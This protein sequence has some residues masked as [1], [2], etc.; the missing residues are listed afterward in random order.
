MNVAVV[1]FLRRCLDARIARLA[2]PPRFHESASGLRAGGPVAHVPG[3]EFACS[4]APYSRDG[5]P[6][7]GG[8]LR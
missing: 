7:N 3:P 5:A 1:R 8:S 6:R 4:A 2:G